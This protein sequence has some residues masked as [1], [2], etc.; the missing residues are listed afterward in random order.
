MKQLIIMAGV[1]ALQFGCSAGPPAPH[2]KGDEAALAAALASAGVKADALRD[3]GPVAPLDD[4]RN[5]AA[6]AWEDGRLTV[7][8]LQDQ[9][10]AELPDLSGA[11][12]LRVLDLSGNRIAVLDAA[13]LPER[14]EELDISGNPVSD[15]APLSGLTR[16]R[17]LSA[18]GSKVTD[19]APL[20]DMKLEN[21]DLRDCKVK[22][23]PKRLP[24]NPDF[25]VDLAGCPVAQPPGLVEKWNFTYSQGGAPGEVQRREG[26]VLPG[27]FSASGTWQSVS[28]MA[29][30]EVPAAP[31][32][33]GIGAAP[34]NVEVSVKSGTLRLY[35]M[36]A[37]D[38]R[39]PWYEKGFVKGHEGLLRK[40]LMQWAEAKPGKPARLFGHLS[41]LGSQPFQFVIEQ[42]GKQPVSGLSWRVWR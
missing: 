35:L 24:G 26:L 34:V 20:A 3:I 36:A 2:D 28:G 41:R 16:L 9:A 13:R 25:R 32:M 12:A 33:D 37:R 14:L 5:R 8:A 40:P 6:A 21:A 7:L 18:R 15:L 27:P 10:L 17:T 22:E 23:L 38:P 31:Q 42:R 11:S 1:V 29:A 4:P 39:G 19:I 30:V